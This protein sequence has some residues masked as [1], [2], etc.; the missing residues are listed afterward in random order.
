M[1][2]NAINLVELQASEGYLLTDKEKTNTFRK[3]ICKQEDA[4]NF[5]E[6]TIEEAEEI[7][8]AQKEV[9]EEA[10]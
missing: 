9:V 4:A 5:S 10:E 3:V 2:T 1:I 7:L 6:I 8:N